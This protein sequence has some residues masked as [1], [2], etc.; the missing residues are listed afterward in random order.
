MYLASI[1]AACL[2]GTATPAAYP[3]PPRPLRLLV[4]EAEFIITALVSEA[5][6]RTKERLLRESE[7]FARDVVVLEIYGLVKNDPGLATIPLVNYGWSCPAPARYRVGTR[8]L[9]FLDWSAK[10]RRF[11][12][13]A[14]S[15]G[16]KTLD[17]DALAVY[18]DRIREQL[19]IER[20]PDNGLRLATQ[21]EWLVKCA[22][23][24]ATRWEGAYELAPAG[25]F[26]FSYEDEE[27]RPDFAAQLSAAQRHRLREAFLQARTFEAGE[28]CLEELLRDDPDP[29]LL[30]WLVAQLRAR[31]L[32]V[33]EEGFCVSSF[34]V[35]RIARRDGRLATRELAAAFEAKRAY[36]KDGDDGEGR[37]Q[38][39][40]ELLA[41]F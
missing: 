29:R 8:V 35:E 27:A 2:G 10:N 36:G 33:E 41:L 4:Q 15:Y 12:T 3:I 31:H 30:E 24:P 11:T 7:E 28:R 26:M 20:M 18:L 25:D 6:P 13:H 21:V 22:E 40:R 17:G 39:V 14:L 34:L 1:L 37:L 9:A 5:D 38:V 19:A 16:A 32:E 23:H